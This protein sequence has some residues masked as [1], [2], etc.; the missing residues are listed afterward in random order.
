MRNRLGANSVKYRGFGGWHL[1]NPWDYRGLSCPRKV[2]ILE[3]LADQMTVLGG[4]DGPGIP[5][6]TNLGGRGNGSGQLRRAPFPRPQRLVH[7][8][9]SNAKDGCPGELRKGIMPERHD[10][11]PKP[12]LM[13]YVHVRE[14]Q[15]VR[16]LEGQRRGPCWL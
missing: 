4:N 11:R 16:D 8:Q 13:V 9:V 5:R 7:I 1:S 2:V 6:D 14:H 12:R 15:A 10:Y 3:A